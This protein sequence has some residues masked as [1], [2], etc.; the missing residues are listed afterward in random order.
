MFLTDDN[1]LNMSGY[2]IDEIFIGMTKS[3]SKT[4]S[5]A[6][7]YAYAGII[8]DINPLHVNEE[9]AKRTRFKGRI[10]HGML[11]ASF[12]STI[13]GMLIPGADAIY[14]GQTCKFLLP[15]YIGDTITATGEVT[16]I[17]PEK[18][19]AHMKTTVVNQRGELVVVG[20]A[21]VMATKKQA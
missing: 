20:E 1:S 3:V 10:A 11:T 4:I 21:I 8:G 15:V 12:F 9:Y 19:I 5:E 2:S 6:D 14:L 7:V 16:K 18:C 13:V 17:I